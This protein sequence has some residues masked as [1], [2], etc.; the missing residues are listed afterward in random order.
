MLQHPGQTK[1]LPRPS[2]HSWLA[3]TGNC[4]VES[5]EHPAKDHSCTESTLSRFTPRKAAPEQIP[6]T[7]S[8]ECKA[9]SCT[10]KL[11]ITDEICDLDEV[12]VKKGR[13]LQI[14][15]QT[16]GTAKRRPRVLESSDEEDICAAKSKQCSA[17]TRKKKRAIS[18]DSSDEE[19]VVIDVDVGGARSSGS[20]GGGTS[21][22]LTVTCSPQDVA[23]SGLDEDHDKI[24]ESDTVLDGSVNDLISKCEE[25]GEGLRKQVELAVI[26]QPKCVGG[27]NLRLKKYQLVGLSWLNNLHMQ[28]VNG[29]LAGLCKMS[30]YLRIIQD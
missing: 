6:E 11:Q 24:D 22:D 8:S 7:P 13:S 23:V 2:V 20:S 17:P 14:S 29:I 9:P 18:A 21:V 16:A 28:G 25:V 19:P 3:A 30:A 15:C 27:E 4:G 26:E 10:Q 5:N 12:S 1:P